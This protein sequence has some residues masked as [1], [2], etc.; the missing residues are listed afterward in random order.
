MSWAT[1][2]LDEGCNNIHFDKPPRVSDGRCYTSYLSSD[3]IDEKLMATEGIQSN[4]SYRE[5]LQKNATKIM[6]YNNVEAY[7][8]LG[9]NPGNTETKNKH[10]PNGYCNP[11][12]DLR[13]KYLSRKQ[14]NLHMTS[15][16]VYFIPPNSTD[17]E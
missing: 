3:A 14:L 11:Q 5:Y 2:Y 4:W 12:S 6:K 16:N 10:I 1:C 7:C 13:N 9:I 15:P 17:Y 8:K